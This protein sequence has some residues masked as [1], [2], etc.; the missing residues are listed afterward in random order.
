MDSPVQSL[1]HLFKQVSGI[2]KF[3]KVIVNRRV[4]SSDWNPGV[5]GVSVACRCEGVRCCYIRKRSVQAVCPMDSFKELSLCGVCGN[6]GQRPAL[7][8]RKCLIT[9][10]S[11]QQPS[12][13]SLRVRSRGLLSSRGR[14]ASQSAS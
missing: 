12:L 13:S 6:F 8:K 9:L 7:R 14:S 1:I 3:R 4:L 2:G 5:S 11:R 10:Q